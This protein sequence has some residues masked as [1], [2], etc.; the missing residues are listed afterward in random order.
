MTEHL[1]ATIDGLWQADALLMIHHR[2]QSFVFSVLLFF[3]MVVLGAL[4][5]WVLFDIK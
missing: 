2:T 4:A 1:H 3:M 5:M